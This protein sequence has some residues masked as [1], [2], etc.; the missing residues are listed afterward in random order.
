[1][2]RKM[3]MYHAHG[4]ISPVGAMLPLIPQRCTSLP[5]LNVFRY[6]P[7]IVLRQLHIARSIDLDLNL[8]PY[9]QAPL[10]SLLVNTIILLAMKLH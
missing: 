7:D 5:K 3:A 10:V 2:L 1:M 6:G 9:P 8:D 4:V